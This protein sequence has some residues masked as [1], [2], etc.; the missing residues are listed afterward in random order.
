MIPVARPSLATAVSQITAATLKRIGPVA[1]AK[2]DLPTFYT[3]HEPIRP[4]TRLPTSNLCAVSGITGISHA[5]YLHSDLSQPNFDVYR[6]ES[7]KNKSKSRE[8]DEE[9]RRAF[10]YVLVGGSGMVGFW[11]GKVLVNEIISF[12]DIDKG[13]V[14]AGV[15]EFDVTSLPEGTGVLTKW[16]GMPV[17]IRHRT[18]AEIDEECNVDLLS[19][20]D[21][22]HDLDR[23]EKPEFMVLVG[24]C[25]HLG[26]IPLNE[27]GNFAPGGYYCPCHGSHYD[28]SGRIRKGPAPLNLEVPPHHF[29]DDTTLVIG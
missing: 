16:R 9:T 15:S 25:T 5:R 8:Q 6:R 11:G 22:Q 24:V 18:Q 2:N 19:L 23:S 29:A 7:T 3:K 1:T 12:V 10:S 17:Y 20:R 14:A 21:P 28:S 4:T 26:C 27:A 13:T